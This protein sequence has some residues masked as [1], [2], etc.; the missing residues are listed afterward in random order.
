[1]S[2][3]SKLPLPSV[4]TLDWFCR[5]TERSLYRV[6]RELFLVWEREWEPCEP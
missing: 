4:C 5:D 2:S 1:L 3:T 6:P